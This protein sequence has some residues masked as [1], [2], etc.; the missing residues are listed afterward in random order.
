MYRYEDLA[1]RIIEQKDLEILRNLH[2]DDST[3]LN[4]LNIELVDE[5]GQIEWWKNLHLK[6]DEKRYV[7]C[8]SGEP[9]TLIGRLRIQHINHNHN[10]CEIGLDIFPQYRNQGYG[11]R[12][13]KMILEFL[14]LHFNMN[15]VYLKV[16]D[17]NPAAIKLYTKIGFRETGR[18]PEYFY[19]HGKYH[20]YIIMSIVKKEYFKS[21]TD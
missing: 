1:F 19:R 21:A 4:L 2:N 3:F 8:L 13:Y 15:M 10:N 12:S 20:D 14:F 9:D 5:E 16:G 6:K 18:L 11:T 17:F 7:I